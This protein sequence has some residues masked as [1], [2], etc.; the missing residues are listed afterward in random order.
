MF[1]SDLLGVAVGL[2][3]LYLLLSVLASA[4]NEMLETVL[5]YRSR[6]L[7]RGRREMLGDATRERLRLC[8]RISRVQSPRADFQDPFARASAGMAF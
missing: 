3:L 2:I 7:E 5:K 4:A 8:S 6:Y 1:G